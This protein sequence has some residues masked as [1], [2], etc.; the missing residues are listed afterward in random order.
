MRRRWH[1][2]ERAAMDA[3]ALCLKVDNGVDFSRGRLLGYPLFARALCL[4][5]TT[6]GKGDSFR[7]RSAL[8]SIE[9]GSNRPHERSTGT[10]PAET[11]PTAS[12]HRKYSWTVTESAGVIVA[13]KSV[14]FYTQSLLFRVTLMT[15]G[16]TSVRQDKRCDSPRP[17][18]YRSIASTLK[19]RG[20]YS[21]LSLP[22]SQGSARAL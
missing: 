9:N 11:R 15:D 3:A 22:E 14:H 4:V 21:T 20:Y 10:L 18:S 12:C 13:S 2:S 17:H 7:G 19:W 5:L 8:D 6:S 1:R 16:W